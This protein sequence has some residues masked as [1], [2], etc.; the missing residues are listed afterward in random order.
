MGSHPE[1]V[2]FSHI[3]F[4]LQIRY[5]RFASRQRFF[6]RSRRRVRLLAAAY[7]LPLHIGTCRGD[8]TW[9]FFNI[10]QSVYLTCLHMKKKLWREANPFIQP[11][12]GEKRVPGVLHQ[13]IHQAYK[14]WLKKGFTRHITASTVAC[15][16][17]NKSYP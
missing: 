14:G 13:P 3:F 9:F 8:E 10:L 1:A 6:I 11:P 15:A 4:Y 7:D 5:W 17:C 2:S 12:G 16:G